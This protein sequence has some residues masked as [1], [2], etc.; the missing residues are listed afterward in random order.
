MAIPN[1]PAKKKPTR[2][3]KPL[4]S[5]KVLQGRT[6]VQ[7]QETTTG[8]N[9]EQEQAERKEVV[10]IVLQNV[11][12]NDGGIIK[13]QFLPDSFVKWDLID[14]GYKGKVKTPIIKFRIP[15]KKFA[16]WVKFMFPKIQEFLK[17]SSNAI[18][19]NV[20]KLTDSILEMYHSAP[21]EESMERMKLS[22][23]E[24]MDSVYKAL[25]E[26]RWDDAMGYYKQ[27]IN[28]TARLYGHQLSPD[29]VRAIEAQ[30]RKAGIDP[31]DRG[32][33]TNSYWDDGTEKFWPTFVRSAKSW[34]EDFGRTVKDEPKMQY[35]I[36]S[37]SRSGNSPGYVQRKLASQGYG[38]M[39]DVS[40]QQ[41]DILMHNDLYHMYRGAVYDISDT[42]GTN[43]FFN[44]PG[45]LNNLTGDLTDAAKA[46]D[47][48]WMEKLKELK[49][50]GEESDMGE[51]DRM[52][53]LSTTLEGRAQ[54]FMEA[55]KRLAEVDR[56][57]GGW[58]GIDFK[59]SNSNDVVRDFFKTIESL[60][61]A[62]IVKSG[63][64][65]QANVDKLVKMVTAAVGFC[66]L[67][68][69]A[70]VDYG[71]NLSDT[72]GMFADKDECSASFLSVVDSII[73]VLNAET[74]RYD[75][76]IERE[77][78]TKAVNEG[79]Y[80][81]YFSLL[82]RMENLY[83]EGYRYELS[84]GLVKRPSDDAIIAFLM[85]L[86]L[87]FGPRQQSQAHNTVNNREQEPAYD[88]GND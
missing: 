69:D 39:G 28:L 15:D 42:E 51:K 54:I 88:I 70:V 72:A 25:S 11:D 73:T 1:I 57:K 66:T 2:Y 76:E 21:T 37:G 36:M 19:P 83:S 18:Y 4:L 41:R 44:A 49:E 9:G 29:N 6:V 56:T 61:N 43:D 46:D 79:Y 13:E 3:I 22:L 82:E 60:A 12:Y 35:I 5:R 65:N 78:N 40:L 47:A 58:K 30:A 45:L 67:G 71:Y 53:A 85:K 8:N 77:E 31:G 84:E 74:D 59:I 17:T 26:N 24:L 87:K 48:V 75:S 38:S 81:P 27:A 86:G 7:G 33:A 62:K 63:W 32:A 68:G 80:R 23:Q 10:E 16:K 64:K 20:D 55:I 50:K 52:R 34:R 14:A